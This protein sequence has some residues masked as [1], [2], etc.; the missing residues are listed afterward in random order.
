MAADLERHPLGDLGV[1]IAL[2]P[3][4]GA[5][6]IIWLIAIYSILFGIMLITLGLRLRGRNRT[7]HSGTPAAGTTV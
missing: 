7:M 2:F 1:L 5:L 4:A 6:S 3:G